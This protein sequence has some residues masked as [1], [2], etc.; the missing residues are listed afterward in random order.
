MAVTALLQ[1]FLFSVLLYRKNV[2]A[3]SPLKQASHFLLEIP[4]EQDFHSLL[5]K[6]TAVYHASS[7]LDLP[8]FQGFGKDEVII[9]H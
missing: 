1:C 9:A 5:E 4:T 8:Y 2:N 6:D 7:A 3:A